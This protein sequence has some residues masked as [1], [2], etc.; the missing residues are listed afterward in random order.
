MKFDV[1]GSQIFASTGGRDFDANG[2]V[3]MFIHGSGQSHLSYTLQGRFLANRGWQVI[4]PDMPAHGLSDGD[5]LTS[6]EEMADWH[7]AVMDAHGIKT[8]H[9]IGHSQGGLIAL[10]LAARYP[11][12]VTGL[13]LIATALAIGVNDH[14]LGLAQNDEPKAIAAM[15]E[16]GHGPDG[17]SHD[18]TMPGQSHMIYGSQVMGANKPGSLF[19]DLTACAAYTGG[20]A[21]AAKINCRT[22]CILADKDK[23]TPMKF[24]RQMASAIEGADLTIIPNAGHM[25]TG[26]K[27]FEVNKALRDF[28]TNG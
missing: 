22:Q 20:P 27:P 10:E 2:D 1:D 19:A 11:E 14:L 25:V 9:V 8:A 17:H 23:M 28:L 15:M 16:W 13:S 21:A 12:R 3:L 5:A 24:G 6:I 7:I 4:T 26:E 18:H